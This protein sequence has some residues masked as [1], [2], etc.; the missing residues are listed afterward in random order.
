MFAMCDA[1]GY[2]TKELIHLLQA[3]EIGFMEAMSK[4]AQD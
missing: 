3:A 2:K 4:N 1:L